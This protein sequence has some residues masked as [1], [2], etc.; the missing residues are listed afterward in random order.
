[1]I[2]AGFIGYGSMG[3]MLIHG[4]ISSKKIKAKEVIVST[5]TI[6]R[7]D[8]LKSRWKEINIAE[9]N[10]E[11]AEKAKYIF[12]CVKPLEVKKILEE[13]KD[14]CNIDKHI[15]SIAGAVTIENIEKI[16]DCKVTKLIPSVTSEVKEGISL[17]C[18][19]KKV[20]QEERDFIEGLLNEISRVKVVE[21]KDFEVATEL[22]SCAPGLISAIFDEFVNAGLRQS[23]LKKEEAVEMVMRTLYGTAKLYVEKR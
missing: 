19:N 2:K 6:S 13:I 1:M 22:T 8:E 17:V 9:S 7:L 21:E 10:S 23:T 20:S 11:V 15:I 12:I 18:H 5:R 3:S 16:I 14:F 4:F